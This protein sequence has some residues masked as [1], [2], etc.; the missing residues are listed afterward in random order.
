MLPHAIHLRILPSCSM[1]ELMVVFVMMFLALRVTVAF[2]AHVGQS[3][4]RIFVMPMGMVFVMV[5]MV[6]VTVVV[7][8]KFVVDMMAIVFM[9]MMVIVFMFM[10]VIVSMFM[11]TV[12][13][14]THICDCPHRVVM[15][16]RDF[17]VLLCRMHAAK[18]NIRGVKIKLNSSTVRAVADSQAPAKEER[19]RPQD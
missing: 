11:I 16:P 1:V 2:V 19:L 9:F 17:V 4:H 13:V 10:M 18:S 7:T 8:V 5:L 3:P 12:F 15:S 14:S 6:A